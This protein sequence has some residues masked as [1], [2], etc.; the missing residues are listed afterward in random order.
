MPDAASSAWRR[1]QN[2]P[3]AWRSPHSPHT[4]HVLPGA[5]L[6]ARPQSC[7]GRN[8]EVPYGRPPAVLPLPLLLLT[9][10]PAHRRAPAPTPPAPLVLA[11]LIDERRRRGD[12]AWLDE[13]AAGAPPGKLLLLPPSSCSRDGLLLCLPARLPGDQP[14]ALKLTCLSSPAPPALL[15]LLQEASSGQPL[16]RP[17]PPLVLRVAGPY[18]VQVAGARSSSSSSAPAPSCSCSSGGCVRPRRAPAGAAPLLL[19]QLLLVV[20]VLSCES[21]ALLSEAIHRSQT[22]RGFLEAAKRRQMEASAACGSCGALK[23]LE[24]HQSRV[25]TPCY[26][27][28]RSQKCS[29]TLL[30][31]GCS[32]PITLTRFRCSRSVRCLS[33]P[34]SPKSTPAAS[35][36]AAAHVSP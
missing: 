8:Q 6:A 22:R 4:H 34:P 24:T 12:D 36:A 23:L 21:A 25:K 30:P 2:T 7:V 29:S 5:A 17:P 31:G 33:S 11:A 16:G 13:G 28:R 10:H 26:L 19:Q 27:S 9:P 35:S 32:A 3:S 20:V 1:C 18:A 15:L 14:S